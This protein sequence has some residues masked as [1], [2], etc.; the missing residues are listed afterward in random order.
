MFDL[1]TLEPLHPRWLFMS[2]VGSHN[3]GT[4]DEN[5]DHDAKVAY[6]PKFSEFYYGKFSHVDTGSPLGDDVTLHPVHEFLRHAFR[7]NMNFWEVFYSDTVRF[8]PT[9]FTPAQERRF[10]AACTNVVVSNTDQN[11]RA[12]LGM[13]IQKNTKAILAMESE[14]TDWRRVWKE[15]QHSMRLLA[16]LKEYHRTGKLVI[17]AN[18]LPI[19]STLWANWRMKSWYEVGSFKNF[20]KFESYQAAFQRELDELR[21]LE[22]SFVKHANDPSIRLFREMEMGFVDNFIMEMIKEN[23]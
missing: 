2:V 11:Y 8:N 4:T 9:F 14:N 20:V 16:M 3:Y 18:Q 23:P 22:D 19:E 15:A 5:S 21:A 10:R 12:M 17:K 7:G 6:L 1:S 13:A